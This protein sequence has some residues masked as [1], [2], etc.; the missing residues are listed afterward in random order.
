MIKPYFVNRINAIVLIVL[1]TWGYFASLSPSL[2][3][4]IPVVFG[5]LLISLNIGLKKE[6]KTIAHIIVL[7]TLLVFLG[8]FKPLMGSISRADNAA[9][10]RVIVMMLSSL[11]AM[12][13]FIKSFIVARKKV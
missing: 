2:T 10:A 13:A 6:N 5:L 8:L 1:G 12:L 9:I 11:Y 3:A 4:L 7:F